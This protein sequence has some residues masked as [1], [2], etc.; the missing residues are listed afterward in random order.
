MMSDMLRLRIYE[1][2][3]KGRRRELGSKPRRNTTWHLSGRNIRAVHSNA[4]ALAATTDTMMI[5]N[6]D[7]TE[8]AVEK[9]S[10]R[11]KLFSAKN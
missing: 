3:K 11:S 1:L 2:Q 4:V 7:K 8:W 5:R 10:Q 6:S 9:D